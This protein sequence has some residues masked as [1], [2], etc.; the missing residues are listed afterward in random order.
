MNHQAVIYP[1]V[2]KEILQLNGLM[3]GRCGSFLAGLTEVLD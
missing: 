3:V 1:T 2:D